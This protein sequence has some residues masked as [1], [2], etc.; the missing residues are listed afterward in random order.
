[1]ATTSPCAQDAQV[2][3]AS[4]ST[5]T[6][7]TNPSGT[8]QRASRP[9]QKRGLTHT[10]RADIIAACANTLDGLRDAALISVGYDTLCRSSVQA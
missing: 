4:A 7:D 6:A 2:G 8:R 3:C 5:T 1:M 9:E 10:I